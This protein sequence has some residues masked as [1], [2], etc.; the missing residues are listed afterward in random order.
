MAV[1]FVAAALDEESTV[2]VLLP[3]SP[4]ECETLYQAVFLTAVDAL[5]PQN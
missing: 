3:C 2:M 1:D 5:T 4:D